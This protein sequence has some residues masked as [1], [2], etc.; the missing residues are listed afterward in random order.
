MEQTNAVIKK[1][2]DKYVIYSKDGK[3]LGEY[4]SKKAAEKRLKQIEYFKHKQGGEVYW[5]VLAAFIKGNEPED[6]V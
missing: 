1:V 2:G 6:R 5:N 4:T 3:K